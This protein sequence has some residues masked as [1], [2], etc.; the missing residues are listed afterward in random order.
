MPTAS[1]A[2]HRAPPGERVIGWRVPP[3]ERDALLQRFPPRY[4]QVVADHVTLRGKV[5]ADSTL[6]PATTAWIVGR[7][8]DARG[9][10]AMVVRIEGGTERPD[11]GTYHITWSLAEGREG[12]ESNDVIAQY[13]WD[14][15]DPPLA[16]QLEPGCF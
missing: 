15:V 6:P 3:G 14:P 7:S 8:D 1:E 4:A 10:E 16:V 13:G 11:G 2:Y 5:G 9:V 12:I